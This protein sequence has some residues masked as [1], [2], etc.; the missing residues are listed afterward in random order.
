MLVVLHIP[1]TGP[2]VLPQ[3]LARAGRLPARHLCRW[4]APREREAAGNAD[5]GG[6]RA[7]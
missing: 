2:T 5:P 3:I 1:P 4:L 7:R 6:I